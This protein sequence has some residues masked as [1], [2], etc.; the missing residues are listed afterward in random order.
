MNGMTLAH[1][2]H[3]FYEAING[4]GTD[5]SEV[6]AILTELPSIEDVMAFSRMFIDPTLY[7]LLIEEFGMDMLRDFDAVL[8]AK[9]DYL[10]NIHSI[11][12]LS[13]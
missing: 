4:I 8:T 10:Q 13:E 11:K 9:P 3:R 5:E 7:Q 6:V 2:Q 12:S 1:L